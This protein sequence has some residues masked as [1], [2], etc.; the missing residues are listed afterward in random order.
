MA[1]DGFIVI[2]RKITKWQWWTNCTM[3]GLFIYLLVKANWSDGMFQ[4]QVVKRG[5]LITSYDKI[6]ADNDLNRKTVIK[7]INLLCG[8]GELLK[9]SNNRW[10]TLTIVN[11]AKYQDITYGGGL[12][13]GLRN[14]LRNGHDIT[15]INKNK[16]INNREGTFTPPTL[17]MVTDYC[18]ER[19]NS[20]NPQLFIDYYNSNGWKVGK[21]SMKDWKAAIRSWERREHKPNPT[22]SKVVNIPDY[23]Q[24]Q[25]EEMIQRLKNNDT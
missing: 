17:E 4:G 11:Y 2:N 24:K 6:A 5:Q 25:K 23:M 12:Q 16:Q 18:K 7:Y 13:N 20:L 9:E 10:T 3:R 8:T 14:G 21:N 22:K 1:K 15:I 19:N